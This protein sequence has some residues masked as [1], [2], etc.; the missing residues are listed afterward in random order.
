LPPEAVKKIIIQGLGT[1][2]K[3]H[4]YELKRSLNI[5]PGE[6][7]QSLIASVVPASMEDPEEF[8]TM[9]KYW[10]DPKVQVINNA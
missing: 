8:E 6:T 4:K 3:E 7:A 2:T 10:T 9:A 5:Q 1:R